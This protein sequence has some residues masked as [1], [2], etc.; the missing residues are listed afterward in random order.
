MTSV[1]QEYGDQLPSGCQVIKVHVGELNQLFNAMD[2]APFRDRDLDPNAEEFIVESA[3]ELHRDRPL[4]LV[5]HLDREAGTPEAATILKDA[6]HGFFENRAR[7]TELKLRQLFKNGRISLV[8]GLGCV[9]VTV[10]A[11]DLV[12]TMFEGWRFAGVVS[13]SLLI[14]GWVAMWRPIE[15]FLY[16]WW[17][18]RAD[19]RLYRRL[20]EM[21]ARIVHGPADD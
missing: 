13:E 6:V 19:V 14:G 9:A 20:S 17:P 12:S 10:I 15:V 21:P 16:E 5:V 3:K 11:G 1:A 18:I 8:I 4:A 7:V 2:P